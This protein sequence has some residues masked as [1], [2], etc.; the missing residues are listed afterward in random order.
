MTGFD[1][2]DEY[3][4]DEWRTCDVSD[5]NNRWNQLQTE[6]RISVLMLG[7][8]IPAHVK[9]YRFLE[10]AVLSAIVEPIQPG[11]LMHDLY[12]RIAAK[13]HTTAVC[14]ERSIR[15]AIQI[16]WIRGRPEESSRLLRRSVSADYERPTN[17]ELIAQIAEHVRLYM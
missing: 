6:R 12:P 11:R 17:S 14:V 9:G 13:Y 2:L 5:D 4:P 8:G 10:E 1:A 3:I 7:L 16:A 15:N